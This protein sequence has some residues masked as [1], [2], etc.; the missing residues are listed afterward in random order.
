MRKMTM[1]VVMV[2]MLVLSANAQTTKP[3]GAFDVGVECKNIPEWI[4]FSG[5]ESYR[6]V[7]DMTKARQ[8]SERTGMKWILKFGFDRIDSTEQVAQEVR[9][10]A[11]LAGLLPYI[12]A[13]QFNEEWYGQAYNGAWGPPSF[14]LFDA[15]A[16]YG[17]E[18]HRVLKQIFHLPVIYV[19]NFI[20]NNRAFGLA[21]YKPMP[22]GF[23]PD[24]ILGIETYVTKGGTWEVDV[25]P[26]VDYTLATTTQ[27]VV[28][29]AQTFKHPKAWNDQWQDG[30]QPRDGVKFKLLMQHPRVFAAWLF[31]W[32]N[33]PNGI[34]GA[35]SLGD[36]VGW[37]R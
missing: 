35:E 8:C 6:S 34:I 9:T 19:D 21:F 28:L 20:N 33:R 31:T 5:L 10:R 11:Q 36:V 29:V 7:A 27:R 22:V 17:G 3:Y 30:P 24:D 1:S 25:Q 15:I 37:F 13:V 2:L 26:Y 32:R 23:G 18:Q 14:E 4:T 16:A 12:V